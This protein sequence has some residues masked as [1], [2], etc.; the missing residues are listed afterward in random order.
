M[1]KMVRRQRLPQW[2]SLCLASLIFPIFLAL[3]AVLLRV[4]L[5]ALA[6]IDS[7][8]VSLMDKLSLEAVLSSMTAIA[9]VVAYIP[10]RALYSGFRW[11][12]VPDD[13]T[14]CI[15]CG[16]NLTGNVSGICPECGQRI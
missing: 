14:E 4:A 3:V 9:V 13:G 6:D 1:T 8:I 2:A 15:H 10:T 5:M 16:S 12:E 7:P 11:E